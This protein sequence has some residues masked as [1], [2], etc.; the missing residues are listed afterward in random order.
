MTRES[1]QE[2]GPAPPEVGIDSGGPTPRTGSAGTPS[3]AVMNTPGVPTPRT[4]SAGTPSAPV[5]NTPGV[6]TPRTG[7]AGTPSA[8]LHAIVEAI[9][10]RQRFVL[11]SHARPD[12]DSIG[13]QLSLAF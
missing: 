5:M 1:S 10:A 7:S 6:P 13:S 3:A 4:G 8:P 2:Q 9:R 11:S 12:G